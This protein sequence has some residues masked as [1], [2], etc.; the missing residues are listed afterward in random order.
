M[1]L[2]KSILIV[3]STV[4]LA[5][6]P[7][8]L[9]A[10][11]ASGSIRSGGGGFGG[12]RSYSPPPATTRPSVIAPAPVFRQVPPVTTFGGTRPSIEKP[13]AL[14]TNNGFGGTRPQGTQDPVIV[15][16][17]PTSTDSFFSEMQKKAAAQDA[18]R[19]YSVPKTASVPYKKPEVNDTA[20][21]S[22]WAQPGAPSHPA[23]VIQSSASRNPNPTPV[24]QQ[25]SVVFV[26][27]SSGPSIGE[28]IIWDSILNGHRREPTVVY[29]SP[30]YTPSAP[31][32]V[33]NPGQATVVPIALPQNTQVSNE[34]SSGSHFWMYLLLVAFIAGI[35]IW[36]YTNSGGSKKR[37]APNYSL[38]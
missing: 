30:P 12:T 33:N 18:L 9:D 7:L 21:A 28:A 15:S 36:W 13:A 29:Q 35:A 17:P 5:F 32:A 20:A 22:P 6:A 4:C 11:S 1:T 24:P 3:V 14:P 10:K 34:K 31:V 37:S 16:K 23:V 19:Q 26:P 8:G 25:P 38:K 2:L 27:Q